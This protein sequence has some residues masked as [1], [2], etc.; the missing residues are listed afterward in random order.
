LTRL[1]DF[2][3]IQTE[4]PAGNNSLAA[5]V[6]FCAEPIGFRELLNIQNISPEIVLSGKRTK[7]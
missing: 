7:K 3:H 5:W 4:M 2:W 6:Y 1:A